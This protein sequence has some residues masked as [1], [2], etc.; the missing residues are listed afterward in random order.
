MKRIAFL[1][2]L[3]CAS[4]LKPQ[5]RLIGTLSDP[6]VELMAHCFR[7][8]G[9]YDGW[10]YGLYNAGYESTVEHPKN[11]DIDLKLCRWKT[12]DVE[13][14]EVCQIWRTAQGI[15]DN[16]RPPY[17]ATGIIDGSTLHILV[18]PG[19]D[20][21]STYIHVP[22]YL[23]TKELGKE[24]VMTI[25]GAPITVTNV[26]DDYTAI[27]GVKI[28]WFTDGGPESAFGIGMNVEIARHGGY[29]YSVISACA[30]GFTSMIVRTTDLIHWETVAI[31]SFSSVTSAST[32]W[33]GVV[34]PLHDDI[35]AFSARLQSEDG[36]IYGTWNSSTGELSNLQL[37]EGG[38]TARPE[39]FEYK[40]NTYLYCNTY[41]P[42]NVEGYGSVYRSTAS[43]Y[44]IS[45][46]GASLEFV[47]KKFVPEGIHY[48]TFYVDR[49]LFIIYSTDSRHLNPHEGRSN[50]AIERIVL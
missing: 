36:V 7:Y 22:Y 28:P 18:C 29:Y 2:L 19:V 21:C 30:G 48:P 12:G 24:E 39:F 38:I 45:K 49:G 4:C 13:N 35:F 11:L 14:R 20:G 43:F 32:F 5:D 26:L 27:T 44:K 42:S 25:D 17:D 10:R 6:S 3:I 33:E 41:G 40:G 37:I 1:A 15:C 47:R 8:V 9:E 23:D 16:F 50:I 46:D 31:P 34:R